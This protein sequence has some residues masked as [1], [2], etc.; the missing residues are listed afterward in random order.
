MAIGHLSYLDLT[1]EQRH[2]GAKAARERV[3]QLLANPFL[4]QDQRQILADR[5][6]HIDAWERCQLHAPASAPMQVEM[7]QDL[8]E[9]ESVRTPVQHTVSVSDDVEVEVSLTDDDIEQTS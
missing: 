2:E 9:V 6:S 8:P 1:P 7:I 3:R 5:L 4:S